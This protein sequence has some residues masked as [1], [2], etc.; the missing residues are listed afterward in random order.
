MSNPNVELLRPIYAEWSRG[1]WAPRFAVYAADYEWGWSDEFLD[2][3]GV[4]RDDNEDK[5]ERLRGWLSQCKDWRCEAERF[6]GEGDTVVALTRYQGRGKTSGAAVNVEGAHVWTFRD[7]KVI[8]LVVYSSRRA[9]L[10]AAGL[11][12]DSV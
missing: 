3:G 7:G 6:V 5:S 10:E 1:N 12:D 9:A 8:R 2:F 4:V 11:A